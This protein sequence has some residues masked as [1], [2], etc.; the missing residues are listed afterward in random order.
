MTRPGHPPE[1]AD[2]D[3]LAKRYAEHGQ[4]EPSAG[5]DRMIRARAESANAGRSPRRPARWVGGLATAMALVL[6][7]GVVV[8]QQ[9]SGPEQLSLPSESA[10]QRQSDSAGSMRE[11]AAPEARRSAA[12]APEPEGRNRTNQ[13]AGMEAADRSALQNAAESSPA[14]RFSA[15]RRELAEQVMADEAAADSD[16][17]DDP[18]SPDDGLPSREDVLEAIELGQLERAAELIEA[19]SE[20]DGEDAARLRALLEAAR[21]DP[22]DGD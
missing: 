6:A 16:D 5:V 22:P 3:D 18:N 21:D 14:A 19:L 20:R 11:E 12:P 9:G 2:Q 15:P 7:V 8:Q 10:I 17:S 13:R 1:R 4:V